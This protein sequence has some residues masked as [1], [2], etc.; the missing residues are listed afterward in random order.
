MK[1][2]LPSEVKGH[3]KEDIQD[4]GLY[5]TVLLA[6]AFL[7]AAAFVVLGIALYRADALLIV[8]TASPLP[9]VIVDPAF[10]LP[11]TTSLAPLPTDGNLPVV[12]LDRA[13]ERGMV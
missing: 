10:Y 3:L 12:Q 9:V 8:P 4:A 11:E 13:L 2:A 7:L 1:Q 6:T 5:R